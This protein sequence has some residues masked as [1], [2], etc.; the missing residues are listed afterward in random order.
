MH[1]PTRHGPIGPPRP[2]PADLIISLEQL[3]LSQLMNQYLCAM[4][5]GT[6]RCG[7]FQ[8]KALIDLSR[9]S[10]EVIVVGDLHTRLDNLSAILHHDNNFE[11]L[12]SGRA[13]L[14]QL[15]DIVHSLKRDKLT[16]MGSSL[17]I[18]GA[19]MRLKIECPQFVYCLRGNHDGLQTATKKN[20]VRQC[21]L[22]EAHL[23]S[24]TPSDFHTGYTA[25]I[26]NGAIMA[27]SGQFAA[28]HSGPIR[29]ATSIE[30]IQCCDMSD[31]SVRRMPQILE[32][33]IFSRWM[34][35]SQGR[36]YEADDVRNFLNLC[37]IPDGHLIVGHTRPPHDAWQ[38]QPMQNHWV[39]TATEDALGYLSVRG[40]EVRPI[41]VR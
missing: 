16:E 33:A 20:D 4:D 36:V 27:I 30:E 29:S 32:E 21:D 34:H 15:G 17:E 39:I 2:L 24:A 6:T 26:E 7:G 35:D 28:V 23:R 5:L 38:Y 9:F 3:R 8:D 31:V 37:Q 18:F 13:V 40:S 22:F 1:N 19:W 41:N 14:L 12:A 25:A 10:G 11:K